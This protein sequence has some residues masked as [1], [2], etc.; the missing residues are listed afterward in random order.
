ML[1]AW[2]EGIIGTTSRFAHNP[3]S[4][5]YHTPIVIQGAGGLLNKQFQKMR[6]RLTVTGASENIDGVAKPQVSD[7]SELKQAHKQKKK[8]RH[9]KS[10]CTTCRVAVNVFID[11][12]MMNCS[13][14]GEQLVNLRVRPDVLSQNTREYRRKVMLPTILE[15]RI[16]MPSS[17]RTT[18]RPTVSSCVS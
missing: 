15:K 5:I 8:V 4:S 10:L 14:L 18:Q 13:D 16:K 9:N 6:R 7:S 17:W 3:R 12:L 11:W 2:A 1:R